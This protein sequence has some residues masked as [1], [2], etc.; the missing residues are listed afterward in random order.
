MRAPLPTGAVTFAFTDI[1]GSTA[2]WERDRAAMQEAVRRHDA[3]L[4]AAIAQHGGSVFKTIGDAFCCAFAR[5][6]DA[7]AAMLAAQRALAAEDFSAIDGLRVR[8]AIH[9]GTADE[10]EGDYFGPAVNKVARLLAIGHGGQILLTAESATLV[11]R[12]LPADVALR[13]LG[14]YRL[15]DFS[16]PQRVH[17]LLAPGLASDFPPLRSLGTLPSD[18]SIVDTAHF[19][20]VASFSGRDEELAAVHAALASDGAIAI[21][22][23]LGGVGKSSIT[24]EYGWRNR[25]DY[26]VIWWLN[27]Q[28][29]DGIIEGLL[30]LGAMFVQGLDQL[31]D[32]RAAAQRVVNT[33]LGGFDKPVLLM[34]DN[35]ED[36]GLMR[37][38]LPR[39]ARALATSRDTAWSADIAAIHLQI[40][41]VETAI[42]YLQ[43]A[44]S[45]ADLSERDARAI[46]QVLGGLPLALA[47]AAAAM[48][49]LRMVSPQRYLERITEHLKNAPR[50]AEYPRSVFATFS[51]AIAQAENQ[52]AGAAAV[53]CFAASFAPDAIPDEL[54]RQSIEL[55]PEGLHPM[56][57]DGAALDLRCVVADELRLDEALGALDRLSLLTFTQSERTYGMHRLVQLAARDLAA[58]AAL[59][60]REGAVAVA[61]AAFPQVD[62]ATW[63]QCERLV[64]HA[65]AVLGVTSRDT[66]LLSA[67]SLANR[68]SRYLW[69][70]GEYERAE[71]LSRHALAIRERALGPNHLD[72]AM[73]LHGLALVVWQQGRYDEAQS[74]NM[75]ALR[76]REE[77]LGPKHPDVA[78]SLNS[79]SL[80]Y[81]SQARYEEAE[82][83]QARALAIREEALGPNHP[84]VAAILDNIANVYRSQAQ[85][86]KAEKLRVRALAIREAALDPDHPDI[87]RSLNNLAA[88]YVDQGLYEGAQP[89][90]ARA[91]AVTEKSLGPN[92]HTA[93]PILNNLAEVLHHQRHYSEAEEL[94]R[95]SLSIREKALGPDHP[96]V[97]VG[98]DRLAEVHRDHSRYEEAATLLKRA[99]LIREKSLGLDHPLTKAT[100][101]ALDAMSLKK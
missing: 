46:A 100:R 13:D 51:M 27:A 60:W 10:R 29:E 15:K 84:D 19:H 68:C 90:L 97:A 78:L 16:E 31:A 24:R 32:R 6:E 53:L 12:A 66:N 17:L 71:Q 62:F 50:G 43:R 5:P 36:E 72:V 81:F 52:A 63:P 85:H 18:L 101:E 67:A 11:N 4:R 91:L 25:D 2:R 23:G 56:L 94:Y 80:A 61:D 35:L 55:Y 77:A 8:A 79:L 47:H 39:T 92:H 93:A 73:S 57:S 41:S 42:E 76:I 75:R 3:I 45:R 65:R 49:N 58:D 44:S 99:L 22:H 9:S 98:L 59:A 82:R 21:V 7:V 95:R 88:T 83:M 33:V 48:R 70:R 1:E 38:W 28:T 30:R 69:E 89:L 54:F 26:S 20:P 37:T 14:A 96:D 74:I 40:W 87:V 64:T 34:F 86:K